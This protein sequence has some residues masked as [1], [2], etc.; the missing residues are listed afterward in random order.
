MVTMKKSIALNEVILNF[1]PLKPER[2]NTDLPEKCLQVKDTERK[3]TD[4]EDRKLF[5]ADHVQEYTSN[6]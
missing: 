2:R 5:R 3:I 1:S 4:R 6:H